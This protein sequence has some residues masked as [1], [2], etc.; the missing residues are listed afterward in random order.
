MAAAAT[1]MLNFG[2][3]VSSQNDLVPDWTRQE[4]STGVSTCAAGPDRAGTFSVPV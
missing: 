4:V 1:M 2:Q 3:N